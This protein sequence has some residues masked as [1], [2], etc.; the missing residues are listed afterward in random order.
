MSFIL[1]PK[2]SDHAPF[3]ITVAGKT[4]HKKNV[5]V[6]KNKTVT[7]TFEYCLSGRGTLDID[8]HTYEI[9]A[10]DLFVLPERCICSYCADKHEDWHKIWFTAT[11]QLFEQLSS[12][13]GLKKFYVYKG[14]NIDDIFERLISVLSDKTLSAEEINSRSALIFTEIILKMYEH[15]SKTDYAPNDA[16]TLKRYMDSHIEEAIS[17]DTLAKLIFRSKSQTIR[18]FKKSFG[19]TPYEYLLDNK[20]SRSELILQGTDISIKELAFRLGFS[21]EHYFSNIFKKKTG[22][23]PSA[24]RKEKKSG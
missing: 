20:I 3:H 21:D 15:I 7:F 12:L 5:T 18:I 13:Y 8:N 22:V 14:L 6:T 16:M 23:S 2:A 4:V 19:I 9:S 17:V 24:Y 11:G 10:G 1:P